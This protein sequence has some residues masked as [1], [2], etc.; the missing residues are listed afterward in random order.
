MMDCKRCIGLLL[1]LLPGITLQTI[2]IFSSQWVRYN[3]TSE[4]FKGIFYT[5]SNCPGNVEGID[6]PVKGLQIAAFVLLAV[7][8]VCTICYLGCEQEHLFCEIGMTIIYPLTGALGFW[9]CME[10]FGQYQYDK[11][12]GFVCCLIA[13][14]YILVKMLVLF[15]Y[16]V[17]EICW[18]VDNSTSLRKSIQI[19]R[20]Y[21]T[22]EDTQDLPADDN[23]AG[24][25]LKGKGFLKRINYARFTEST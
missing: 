16:G 18:Q 22:E 19:N 12:W 8:V 24:Y 7:S 11:G 20:S 5:S 23:D 3:A 1:I 17:Y 14:C 9:G 25:C 15:C 4:C 6:S 2:G 10:V 13:S 21:G